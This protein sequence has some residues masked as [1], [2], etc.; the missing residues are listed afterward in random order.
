M[1]EQDSSDNAFSFSG[2]AVAPAAGTQS[3][4]SQS[5]DTGGSDASELRTSLPRRP[6]V[7]PRGRQISTMQAIEDRDSTPG[8]RRSSA[9]QLS[10]PMTPRTKAKTTSSNPPSPIQDATPS[11]TGSYQQVN[12]PSSGSDIFTAYQSE[13]AEYK[14]SLEKATEEESVLQARLTETTAYAYQQ[15]NFLESTTHQ[16]MMSM[17]EQLQMLNFEL[18]AAQQEDEGATYRIEELER[19]Q[20]MSNEAASHLEFRYSRLRSEFDEQMGQ[21]NA[22]MVHVGAD[23]NAHINQLRLELENAEMN[24]KQEALAV[25]YAND[26]TCALQIEM[27][28]VAN[29]NQTMKHTMSMNVRRLETELDAA[30]MKRDEIMK[31]FRSNIRSEHDRYAECEHHLALEESQLRLQVIHNENLQSRLATSE[32]KVSEESLAESSGMRDM[33]IMGL[34]SELHMK[35]SLLD[36]MQQQ[37]TESKNQYHE[38]SCQQARRSSPSRSPHGGVIT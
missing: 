34:R 17:T 28:E 32:S 26:Q 3:N 10:P 14:T 15:F 25:G 1:T 7:A 29:Q 31:E 19:Y 11:G 4:S 35:Q 5:I 21:A 24:A 23:A 6:L 30:D 8:K 27:L 22:I 2:H 38:L 12:A 16:E 20:P 37:L 13:L 36:R 33:R 18:Q 9:R